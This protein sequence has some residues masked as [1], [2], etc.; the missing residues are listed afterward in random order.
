MDLDARDR[1]QR[2][3]ELTPGGQ[4]LTFDKTGV[5]FCR[6]GFSRAVSAQAHSRPD[7]RGRRGG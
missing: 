1:V 5:R 4:S 3:G 6:T 7:R 2:Q